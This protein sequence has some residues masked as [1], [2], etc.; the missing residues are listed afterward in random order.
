MRK[1]EVYLHDQKAGVLVEVQKNSHYRFRYLNDYK[2]P[3]L[4][5]TMPV[6]Q[7]SFE[8]DRFPPFFDGLLPEGMNLAMLLRSKKIDRDDSF[9][10]LTAVGQDTVGAV[11]VYEVQE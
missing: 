10:Q 3:P 1:A 7:C 8:Y 2:G 5:V 9:S 4:S 11:T 6:E